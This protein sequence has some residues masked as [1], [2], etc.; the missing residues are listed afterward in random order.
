M[1]RIG[2]QFGRLTIIKEKKGRRYPSGKLVRIFICKCK[3]GRFH[4]TNANALFSGDT[5]SCGC[6]A[7]EGHNR[8]HGMTGTKFY[9]T[10]IGMKRRA[11]R[12]TYWKHISI[13]ER[14]KDFICF[15]VDMYASFLKH[16]EKYGEY[17]TSIDRI[18]NSKGYSKS[19]CRWATRLI[20]GQNRTRSYIFRNLS[21]KN[22]SGYKGLT[23]YKSRNQ[24]NV[25]LKINNEKVSRYF[26][27]RINAI[28]F[29][30][31]YG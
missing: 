13:C 11:G 5:R 2:Q 28:K 19:N 10:W 17:N 22:T 6:L 9:I 3:C 29:I 14:W 1:D 31:R 26:D 8:K 27:K 20:Q 23:W 24:W 16:V 15:K 12:Q 30:N 4:T 18:D 7:K 21:K 25:R